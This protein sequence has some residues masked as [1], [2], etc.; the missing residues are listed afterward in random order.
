MPKR[1]RE[2]Q[3]M[4]LPKLRRVLSGLER[5][6]FPK[7]ATRAVNRTVTTVRSRTAKA[8]AKRMGVRQKDVRR[9]M[10]IRK[11]RRS[12][13]PQARLTISG[14]ALNLIAFKARQTKRGV[15][16]APWNR[17]R[18]FPMTFITEINGV[19]L[20]MVRRKRGGKRVGRLPIRGVLGP[21][22]AK[23]AASEDLAREREKVVAERFRVEL[24]EGLKFYV[25]RLR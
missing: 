22:I 6:V 7:A 8:V 19:K 4:G 14:K 24:E 11:A 25:Q 1:T 3:I 16:A 10:E 15:S 9:R 21:G 2:T 20:V 5:E 17:R 13:T 23:T 18:I 12:A